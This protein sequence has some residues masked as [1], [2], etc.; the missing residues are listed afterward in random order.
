[1]LINARA[2]LLRPVRRTVSFLDQANSVDDLTTYTF[3]AMHIPRPG[4]VEF[5]SDFA[6]SDFP[7]LKARSRELVV[8]IVHGEDA[9][10]N[11]GVSSV[12]I[13]GI[14]GME[15]VDRGGATNAINTA[16][17]FWR[18]SLFGI[19]NT[20]V[21]VT[22]SEAVTSCAVGVLLVNCMSLAAVPAGA[23]ATGTG[24]LSLAINASLTSMDGLNTCAIAGATC[25]GETET[26]D[27]RVSA[28]GANEAPVMLYEGSNAEM[29]WSGAWSRMS[30][31]QGGNGAATANMTASWSGA[32]AGDAAGIIVL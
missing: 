12:T 27:W 22:W 10:A 25:A 32:G 1:M 16:V 28:A 19:T 30:Q 15:A 14:A 17:Y 7:H 4:A 24:D 3:S 20:D 18:S 23:T 31:Y 5:N 8:V 26:C 11:F 29:A 13:G 6:N 9:A 21:V 2:N